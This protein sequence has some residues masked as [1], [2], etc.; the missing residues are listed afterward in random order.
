MKH[1]ELIVGIMIGILFGIVLTG[2]VQRAFTNRDR[3]VVHQ[4]VWKLGDDTALAIKLN[5][6]TGETWGLTQS[7]GWKPV[8][9]SN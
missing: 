6:T 9:T 3:F 4:I 8:K 5:T 1:Q 7:G 2:L